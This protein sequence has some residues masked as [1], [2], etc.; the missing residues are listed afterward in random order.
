MNGLQL[1]LSK[2]IQYNKLNG[3]IVKVLIYELNLCQKLNKVGTI[4]DPTTRA[5]KKLRAI[6]QI[7]LLISKEVSTKL[8]TVHF[9]KDLFQFK[10]IN[11][12][13]GKHPILE[14]NCRSII[15]EDIVI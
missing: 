8:N 11:K 4:V 7:Y 5:R 2:R 10:N 12:S 6:I 14:I 1:E 13:P 9:I 3:T 15:A